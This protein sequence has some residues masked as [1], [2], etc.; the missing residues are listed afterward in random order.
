M[1]INSNIRRYLV[2]RTASI[3][4]PKS[5]LVCKI[6]GILEYLEFYCG[7][8]HKRLLDLVELDN[9]HK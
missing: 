4:I 3:I 8:E 5:D 1:A 7:G 9:D 2:V 6:M